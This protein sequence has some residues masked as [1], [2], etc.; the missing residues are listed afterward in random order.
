[1]DPGS[2]EYSPTVKDIKEER[3]LERAVKEELYDIESELRKPDVD[4]YTGE[5]NKFSAT[6]PEAIWD[7]LSYLRIDYFDKIKGH[8]LREE[9]NKKILATERRVYAQ[10][11]TFIDSQINKFGWVNS[12]LEK[13]FTD[14]RMSL[15]AI[16]EQF[17]R[18]HGVLKTFKISD[19]ELVDFL[20]E[21]NRL[22]EK[23][24]RYHSE[25][26]LFSFEKIEEEV[27]TGLIALYDSAFM[28]SKRS[29]MRKKM[30][31]DQ[32]ALANDA[33]IC[34]ELLTKINSLKEIVGRMLNKNIKEPCE[35]RAAALLKFA[36]SINKNILNA[37][38]G[39]AGEDEERF[40]VYHKDIDWAWELLGVDKNATEKEAQEAYRKLAREY[41][42]DINKS[43]SSTENMKKINEAYEFIK[44]II[45]KNG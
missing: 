14:V 40:D 20:S 11:V 21:L 36:E 9:L 30:I 31:A 25:P 5:K 39:G 15:D 32:D 43:E 10:Y 24:D 38:E 12:P 45:R 44:R 42:P 8:D 37:M 27:Q 26:T 35:A 34:D 28:G 13:K 18:A 17:D 2:Q 4:P 29:R 33:R 23:L 41:H 6:D 3:E 16:N 19:N 22:H 7:R 1:M